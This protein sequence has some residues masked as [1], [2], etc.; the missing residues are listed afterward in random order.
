VS[1]RIQVLSA[2]HR[3]AYQATRGRLGSRIAGMPVLLLATTGRRTGRRRTVPLT[4]I[5]NEGDLVLVASYGG[6]PTHP[7]WFLNLDA[8]PDVEV[9]IGPDRRE[10]QARRAT[11]EERDRLW[12]RVVAT[13]DGYGRYQ[14]KTSREIPLALLSPR[15]R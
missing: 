15:L 3:G 7:A 10:M 9:Q 13:Y 4:Y 5:E 12:P 8:N 2:V 1:L 11:P 6:S 14:A